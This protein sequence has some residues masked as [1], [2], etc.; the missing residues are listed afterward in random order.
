MFDPIKTTISNDLI[1]ILKDLGI[2]DY[3]PYNRLSIP[4]KEGMGNFAFGCFELTKIL[5]Q[6]PNEIAASLEQTFNAKESAIKAK[7]FGPYLN[8]FIDQN[9]Q[10][11]IV[12]EGIL[13]GSTFS[14]KL[15]ENYPKT[16]IEYSQPN[17][18]KELHVGHMRNL[19]LGSAM[20]NMHR[21][22]D[23]DTVA[24]TFPGDVGTHVA[25]CL[26]YLTEY[27]KE[28]VPAQNKGAWLGRLYTK[29]NNLLE[30]QK[31]TNK[32]EENRKVLT[33]ILK[34]LEA[35]E[36]KYFDLWK[37]TRAWSIELMESIY[38]WAGVKFDIWYWESD[39]DSSSVHLVKE[40]YD[41]GLFIKDDGAIGIDLSDDKLG[42]CLLLK[43]DGT[44]LYATKDIELARR[45]F[46]DYKIE[47]NVYIVDNRQAR[48]FK[49]V[50]KTLEK[51]G[52]E[53]AKDCYHMQYEMV[54]LP[55]GAMSSRK[56][57]IVA[58]S[59][60][61]N[62]MQDMITTNYLS[63]YND[64][65]SKDE[66]N[67][68]AKIIAEGA[69]KYG[70]TKVDSNKKIV[71]DMNEW[72]KLDGE[73]GPYIQYVCARINS[74]LEKAPSADNAN[75]ALLTKAEEV[76]LI[77]KLAGFNDIIKACIDNSKTHHLTGYLY[78]LAKLFNSFYAK[79]KVNDETNANLTSA[80]VSLT[81][82]VLIQL[83]KGLELLGIEAP[84]KM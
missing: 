56:G 35:K 81:K 9:L 33:Q 62:N 59:D 47:K 84:K 29:G 66:I 16:M 46:E 51:M 3:L 76:S 79:H 43:S 26:W 37:T 41:K 4:P 20:I 53:Q 40:Y 60:L 67:H 73:S 64:T 13:T 71:F 57:N 23:I 22:C 63:K 34:E 55:D 19:C 38:N 74:I 5:K 12:L 72:L 32:E 7:A 44:G 45:K 48:H 54:E 42:F 18:H 82:S 25:K 14:T 36:G 30:D 61:I 24:T 17:T 28:E 78:E 2:H 65:W 39:V 6:K 80:R 75:Y 69:I 10:N 27:N 31:G 11:K 70:M 15:T 1:E 21:Y 58:I 8:F 49:Q 50:F 52:F 68:T 83:T 77:N